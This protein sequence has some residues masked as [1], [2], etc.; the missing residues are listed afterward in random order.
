M[1]RLKKSYPRILDDL[2][3]ITEALKA[4]H[5]VGDPIP[6]F[7]RRV[8]KARIPSS[9]MKRGKRGGFR[10]VYYVVLDKA[11]IGILTVYAKSRQENI[12][13]ASIRQLIDSFE[14]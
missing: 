14:V 13:S 4:G 8:Y 9:D 1:R 2:K 7:S 6:G 10:I 12:D 5:L 3:E 11:V